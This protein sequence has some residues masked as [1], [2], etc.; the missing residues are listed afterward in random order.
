MFYDYF[1]TDLIG[2][3]TLVGDEEGL[4]HIVFPK[5]QNSIIIRDDWKKKPGFFAP[6]KAQLRAYFKGEWEPPFSSEC[7]RHCAQSRTENWSATKPSLK[8]LATPKPSGPWAEPTE[9][10]PYLSLCRAIGVSAAM[11]L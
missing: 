8:L 6:V 9:E 5:E 4:R 7:G 11:A 1:E 10:T 3:L 2:T